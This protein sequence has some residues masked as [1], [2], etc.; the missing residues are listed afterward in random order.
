LIDRFLRWALGALS[1]PIQAALWIALG[2]GVLMMLHVCADVAGRTL[3]NQP[4]T[5]TT[6]VVAAFYMVATAFLPWAWV[7]SR[8]QHIR[9]DIFARI[10]PPRVD[11]AVDFGVRLLTIGYL[12]VF[13][14][15]TG[16]RALQQMRAG[17][18]WQVAGG[19]LAVWPSRWLLPLA[20]ALMALHLLLR[21]VDHL[22][23]K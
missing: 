5:G 23:K 12:A 15:Q 21:L 22:R 17:E 8:D 11:R 7:A 18:S 9:A 3:F 2:A 20:G 1:W 13:T 4:L 16:V 6:E 19:Y 14:W 10:G